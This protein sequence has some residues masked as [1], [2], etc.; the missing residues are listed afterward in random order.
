MKD[1]LL[2]LQTTTQMTR[3]SA[4]LKYQWGDFFD[5]REGTRRS[6]HFTLWKEHY[7]QLNEQGKNFSSL[8][9][10]KS[11]NREK[12][13]FFEHK[14]ALEIHKHAIKIAKRSHSNQKQAKKEKKEQAPQEL[15]GI[16]HMVADSQ[17]SKKSSSARRLC[18]LSAPI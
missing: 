12:P 9:K 2:L 7:S 11:A 17:K 16:T 3:T 18:R 14:Q 8:C 13:K 15:R 10:Q 6:R 5:R 1:S 4:L